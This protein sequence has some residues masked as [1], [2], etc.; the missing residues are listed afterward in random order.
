M[1]VADSP[2]LANLYGAHFE[3][4]AHLDQYEDIVFY[5]RYI[6]DCLAIIEANSEQEAINKLTSRIQF[7]GCTIEWNAS[8]ASQPFLD[9]LI[10]FDE[11]RRLQHMPYRKARN[12]QERIPWI[13]HHPL[14]VK[15][16]TF[17]GEMS[18][19]ATLCSTRHAYIKACKGLVALYVKRGYPIDLCCHWLKNNIHQRWNNRLEVIE[20]EHV[21]V[22]VLK[23]EYN[24]IWNY[25]NAKELGNTMFEYWRDYLEKGEAGKLTAIER[26]YIP[27]PKSYEHDCFSRLTVRLDV[28]GGYVPELDVRQIGILN[29]RTILSR[30][31]TRNLMDLASLWK[32]VVFQ[33]LDERVLEE[34][35]IVPFVP[36]DSGA[37]PVQEVSSKRKLELLAED[38]DSDDYVGH[39]Q[40]KRARSPGWWHSG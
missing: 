23:T 39:R 6:D 9:M 37:L 15:R 28:P 32:K 16:G 35:D 10:Y 3:E 14:D 18:R 5:G 1:G 17:I 31:R 34:R 38:S 19:L 20:R 24:P 4:K 12:H 7:D 8:A 22:L 13:S 26:D 21:D 33:S 2:D 29:R 25:F 36:K 11:D 27:P 40:H 30:K